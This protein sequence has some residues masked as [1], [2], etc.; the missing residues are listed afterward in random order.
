MRQPLR[1]QVKMVLGTPHA[2]FNPGK[3]TLFVPKGFCGRHDSINVAEK[4]RRDQ[5]NLYENSPGAG[6]SGQPVQAGATSGGPGGGFCATRTA[7]RRDSGALTNHG[8]KAEGRKGK[9]HL[10]LAHQMRPIA[11]CTPLLPIA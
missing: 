5:D 11:P 7:R 1:P 10:G 9:I 2:D 4:V 6:R 8:E 3:V